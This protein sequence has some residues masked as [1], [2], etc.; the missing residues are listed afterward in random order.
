MIIIY[1]LFK[2]I[3]NK[4]KTIGSEIT[5]LRT[6]KLNKLVEDGN[7]PN[8]IFKYQNN[9][10]FDLMNYLH[11]DNIKTIYNETINLIN[12]IYN[13]KIKNTAYRSRF[14]Y[15]L[16][17]KNNMLILSANT[18]QIWQSNF[19]NETEMINLNTNYNNDIIL[20][21]LNKCDKIC[22]QNVDEN[23][24]NKEIE[25]VDN[26]DI[27]NT[28]NNKFNIVLVNILDDNLND[29]LYYSIIYN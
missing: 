29:E 27:I 23:E 10:E 1:L 17:Y 24:I 22:I 13:K 20:I 8:I 18:I 21:N 4:N 28:I 9:V 14:V 15:T 11:S 2:Y 16:N 25:V 19:K 3:Q 26:E 12:R 6:N 7:Y 5:K